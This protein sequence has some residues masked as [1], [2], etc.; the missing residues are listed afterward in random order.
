[1]HIRFLSMTV[2]HLGFACDGKLKF[3]HAIDW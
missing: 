2:G 3:L 1:M